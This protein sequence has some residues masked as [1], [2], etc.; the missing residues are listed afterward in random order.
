MRCG[1]TDRRRAGG[2]TRGVG[3]GRRPSALGGGLFEDV[4]GVPP[5]DDLTDEQEQRDQEHGR[6]QDLDTG[7]VATVVG[8]VDAPSTEATTSP[9]DLRAQLGVALRDA[10][11]LP[12]VATRVDRVQQVG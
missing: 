6:E 3:G 5:H 2:G 9:T 10:L 12:R 1:E 4:A 8:P 7:D 11:R